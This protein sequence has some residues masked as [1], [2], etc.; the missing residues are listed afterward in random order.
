M[1]PLL[2]PGGSPL[3]ALAMFPCVGPSETDAASRIERIAFGRERGMVDAQCDWTPWIE[4]HEFLHFGPLRILRRCC[5]SLRFHPA[6]IMA[7]ALLRDASGNG[8]RWVGR[9]I[10][11]IRHGLGMVPGLRP[12][13]GIR[14][15]AWHRRAWERRIPPPTAFWAD[16]DAGVS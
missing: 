8:E 15:L 14:Q 7:I 10:E 4:F 13:P 1:I 9:V 6:E 2:N 16:I 5:D 3:L 11:A 12:L